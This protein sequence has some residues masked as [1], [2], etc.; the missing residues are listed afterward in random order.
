MIE[1]YTKLGTYED[2]AGTIGNT[3]LVRL[4]KIERYFNLKNELYAKVEFFNPG[5][6]IKDRIGKYMIEGRREMARLSKA[7]LSSNPPLATLA[8]VSPWSRRTRDT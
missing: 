5:G 3:P 1:H 8:W 6:S 2:I 7:A 4:R